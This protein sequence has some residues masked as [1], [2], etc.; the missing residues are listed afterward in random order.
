MLVQFPIILVQFAGE[1]ISLFLDLV[2]LAT[3]SVGNPIKRL[4]LVLEDLEVPFVLQ[5]FARGFFFHCIVLAS[6]GFDIVILPVFLT[7]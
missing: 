6:D 1:G 3:G 4:L 5:C 2:S 7:I